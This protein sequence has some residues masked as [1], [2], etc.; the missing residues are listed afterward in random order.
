MALTQWAIRD[1]AI[2]PTCKKTCSHTPPPSPP[3]TAK[4]EDHAAQYWEAFYQRNGDRFFRDRH[5]FEREFP[6]LLRARSV[7]EVGCGVGNS[8]L[9]LLEL[10][11]SCW[12]RACDFSPT[13][14]ALT[15]RALEARGLA[16]RARAFV[17]DITTDDLVGPSALGS[18]R[19]EVATMVFVLSA[20]SP[21]LQRRALG[22]VARALAPGGVLLFRDYA[23]GDL[24]EER[25]GGGGR[26]QRLGEA[27][28]VRGDGTTAYY[29]GCAEL[30]ALARAAGLESCPGEPPHL[31]RR[32]VENRRLKSTMERTFVQ[33]RFRK[34][35]EVSEED[36][37]AEFEGLCVEENGQRDEGLALEQNQAH[38]VDDDDPT[39]STSLVVIP[40][41]RGQLEFEVPSAFAT[42]HHKIFAPVLAALSATPSSTSAMASFRNALANSCSLVELDSGAAAPLSFWALRWCRAAVALPACELD[43]R[44]L[45]RNVARNAAAVVVERLRVGRLACMGPSA[46]V[47]GAEDLAVLRGA[48]PQGFQAAWAWAAEL[49]VEGGTWARN[50]W[51][52]LALDLLSQTGMFGLA[53]PWDGAREELA[54]A[55]EAFAQH[56]GLVVT[57][58]DVVHAAAICLFARPRGDE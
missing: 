30:E 35:R 19:V 26:R 9:P 57:C 47:P 6:D 48:V 40:M 13:G 45:K 36:L 14:V 56:A 18:E 42:S 21:R 11:P 4:Y 28:Y 23:R 58:V 24:A 33:A 51:L 54:S 17:A 8:L 37:V 55:A 3:S 29:F 38:V 32:T 44:L 1:Q 52:T 43:R 53:A 46:A 16:G 20:V 34:V 2:A 5:Y 31:H 15:S 22:G 7:L 50:P 12:A 41:H 27:H 10:N 25:L 49:G 39:L